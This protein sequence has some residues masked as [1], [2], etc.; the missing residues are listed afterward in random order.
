MA[1]GQDYFG[2]RLDTD[3]L[4]QDAEKAKKAFDEIGKEAEKQ[5]SVI[6]K[7]FSG[8]TLSINLEKE[9][10]N[11]EKLS[12]DAFGSISSNAQRIVREIQEDT[13]SLSN[14]EKMMSALNSAYE[15]GTISQSEYINAASRLEVLHRNISSAIQQNEAALKAETTIIDKLADDSMTALQAKVT[16][17]TAEYMKLSKAQRESI[18][19]ETLLKNI[20][21]VNAELNRAQATMSKYGTTATGQ[22]NMLNVSIQQIARELPSLTMSPQMFFLAISNNLPMFTDALA[23]ARKEF[24]AMTAAGKEAVPVW[25]QVAKSLLSWQTALSL[26]PTLLIVYSDEIGKFFESFVGGGKKIDVAK[27]SIK[28]FKETMQKGELDAQKEVTNLNLLY[29]ATQDLSKSYNERKAAVDAL[30]EQYPSYFKNISDEEIMAGNAADAY[31][32]LSNAIIASAKARAAQDEMVNQ[33]KVVLQNV[34]KINEA[35]SRLEQAQSDLQGALQLQKNVS[36]TA[37]PAESNFLAANVATAAKA[38]RDIENEIANYRTEVYKAEKITKELQSNINIEDLMFDTKGSEGKK[39]KAVDNLKQYLNELL[40][41]QEDNEERQIELTKTGTEKQLA[42]IELRYSRQIEAVKKLQEDLKKAQG[43]KLTTEQQGIFGTAISG[44]QGMKQAETTS[45]QNKQLEAE[46]KAMLDYLSEYGDYWG[47]R[48]AIAEKYQDEIAKE[49]TKYGKMSLQAEMT[50]ALAK[51]DDEAQKKT[52]VITKLFGNMADKSVDE[53]RKIADEA[54]QLLAFIEGGTYQK[55]NAFGITEEQFKVL[56]ESPEKLESIKNEIDNVRNEADKAEPTLERIKDLLQK[57]FGQKGSEGEGGKS[58]LEDWLNDLNAEVGKVIQSVNF[59]ANAF[60]SLGD[61]FGSD[62]LSG[63]A[64]GLNVAMDAVN[65]A[66]QG[67][68]AGSLF[69]PIGSAAGAAV[70]VVT[71]LAGSIAKIHDK[72]NEKAIQELQD[73]IDLLTDSYDDLGRSIDKAYSK[74]ASNLIEQQN[75]L[76]EQQKVLIQ[77]QIKEEQDKKKTDE[78]RIKEWQQQLDDINEQIEDNKEA[79]IDAIFGE[80]LQ[81]AIE[82][83]ADSLT[84]AWSEGADASESARDTVKKM[85]QQMVSESIKAA[86]QA[87]GSME[88]IRKKL[89]EF[90]ADN[91]LTGWEQD[92]IYNMADKLQQEIDKQFGWAEGLFGTEE[93]GANVQTATAGG[94]E[95]MSQDTANELNGR[96]TALYESSLRIETQISIGNVNLEAAKDA[97]LQMRDLT[98]NCY[99][100]LVEIRE[101]TGAVVKPIQQMQKDITEMKNTIKERL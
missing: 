24:Q 88:E 46:K 40:G 31:T 58:K 23:N 91:V 72:K 3:K 36:P 87:S 19:G 10:K 37:T 8:T 70:G 74:D 77:N 49:T 92:Y 81:S 48:K 79:A 26:L 51:L 63:I 76:L 54:E 97:A 5:G 45:V 94:F 101:N 29:D 6:D 84:N 21:E 53:M 7:A 80:D 95:T 69:G 78:N 52:S 41:L 1:E 47:K 42:L 99:L 25:K 28:A 62:A 20:S 32:R 55:D 13:L 90:Y 12:L 17:L 75:K 43:G 35:Y 11:I 27:E 4:Q 100:E 68:Q 15:K 93:T 18:E 66:M 38:V 34:T 60:S 39:Q 65:S 73:Q 83:F 98:Q 9:L 22:F 89:Q 2:I 50:E 86:I 14:V 57:I 44:L 64:D 59:L 61:A 82:N 30:Q 85:M 96:F 56:S 67:A 33:Q 71:S 16:L